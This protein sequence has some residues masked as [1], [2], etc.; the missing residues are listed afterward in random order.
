MKRNEIKEILLSRC[1]Y[2]GNDQKTTDLF[3][4]QVTN[5]VLLM[6]DTSPIPH[7]QAQVIICN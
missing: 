3:T 5:L 6:D 2:A 4:K 1:L 7:L